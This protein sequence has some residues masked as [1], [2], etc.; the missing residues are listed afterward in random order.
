L[1][2]FI[3]RP[4]TPAIWVSGRMVRQLPSSHK[5]AFAHTSNVG[6]AF[7]VLHS[8]TGASADV[9]EAIRLLRKALEIR[10]DDVPKAKALNYLA[11]AVWDRYHRSKR[12]DHLDAY[13]EVLSQFPPEGDDLTGH[14]NNLAKGLWEQYDDAQDLSRFAQYEQ[15]VRRLPQSCPDLSAHWNNV[16][17]GQ[18]VRSGAT[19][20]A[21]DL[22]GAIQS[23]ERAVAGT[24]RQKPPV[25]PRRSWFGA[26]LSRPFQLN[27]RAVA[28][29]S[30]QEKRCRALANLGTALMAGYARAGAPSDLER[31]VQTL[32][33]AVNDSPD[34]S[35]ELGARLARLGDALRL[36]YLQTKR[37]GDLDLAIEKCKRA[38]EQARGSPDLPGILISRGI[39][40]NDRYDLTNDVADLK[41]AI[42]DFRAAVDT[43]K[44]FIQATANSRT[45]QSS[46]EERPVARHRVGKGPKTGKQKERFCHCSCRGQHY[47]P[48]RGAVSAGERARAPS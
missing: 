42:A 1:P 30:P 16:G 2:S 10:A 14:W 41:A 35:D 13:A 48:R 11:M 5:Y 20:A 26:L 18:L 25:P 21:A 31:A 44:L 3:G 40:F 29:D 12:S 47:R 22:H 37:P 8:Q 15:V 24:P 36:S 6:M 7:A 4:K 28:L 17:T 38:V 46:F 39:S 9:E 45:S 43:T 23:F 32:E 27:A 33:E 34:G 19:G